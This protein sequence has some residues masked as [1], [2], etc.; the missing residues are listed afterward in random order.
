MRRR[1]FIWTL[2]GGAV[3]WPLAARTQ[4]PKMLRVGYSGMLLRGAPHYTA[5][6]RRMAELGYHIRM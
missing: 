4:S 6:E 5:F 2:G 3:A 1:E